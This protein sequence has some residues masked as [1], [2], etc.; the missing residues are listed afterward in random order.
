M[1]ACRLTTVEDP[2]CRLVTRLS[3]SIP[4]ISISGI[5]VVAALASYVYQRRKY[6]RSTIHKL[7]LETFSAYLWRGIG[8]RFAGY[9]QPRLASQLSLRTFALNRLEASQSKVHIPA[10]VPVEL[11]LDDMFVPLTAI[12]SQKERVS[13]EQI[14]FGSYRHTILIGDPGSGKSTIVRKVYRDICRIGIVTQR[15]SQIPVL[16]D[17]KDLDNLRSSPKANGDDR[18]ESIFNLVK[19]EV[20]SVKTYSGEK[21][22]EWFLDAGRLTVMLDGLDEVRTDEF[23]NV[24]KDILALRDQL[25]RRNPRNRLVVTTRRQLYV[26]LSTDFKDA[27]EAHLT[28]EP[29]TAN[30][31]YEF[32]Q[33]WYY[34]TRAK[35]ASAED[36]QAATTEGRAA[37]PEE[38]V[39]RIFN[40]LAEQPNIRTMCATPLVLG[41][42]VAM[43]ELT[44]GQSLPETRPDFYKT[45]TDE[46]LVR[47][48]SRQLGLTTG[49]SLL[50]RNRQRILGR[51]ALEH[52]L[53]E[54]QSRNS[55]RWQS[56]VDLL[57]KEE[58]LPKAEAEIRLRELSRDTG[59][60]T[61][62]QR[63]ET[64]T[65]IHLTFCEFLAAQAISGGATQS[66]TDI[67]RRIGSAAVAKA[68]GQKNVER[69]AE[70]IIFA[71]ALE[72]NETTRRRRIRWI[73]QT[74]ILDIALRAI[75]DSQPYEDEFV[76]KAIGRIADDIANVPKGERDDQWLYLFRQMAI[77]LRDR[78]RVIAGISAHSIA[79]TAPESLASFIRK[80]IGDISAGFEPLFLSYI[81]IDASG[82]LQ[83]ARSMNINTVTQYPA[84]LIGALD[85]P[86]ILA[87][88]LA[89]FSRGDTSSGEWAA[90]LAVAALR[91]ESLSV[92]LRRITYDERISAY[93]LASHSRR[94]VGWHQ[95]WLIR[96][97]MLGLLLEAGCRSPG[98]WDVLKLLSQLPVL[99][100][101]LLERVREITGFGWIV[102]GICLSQILAVGL[103]AV[104]NGLGS[105]H[106]NA[107]KSPLAGTTTVIFIWVFIVAYA[108]FLAV[109]I[110]AV[111]RRASATSYVIGKEMS[112]S[113]FRAADGMVSRTFLERTRYA[114]LDELEER[115][116][117]E[118][119]RT[120]LQIL[121]SFAIIH[122]YRHAYFLRWP[123][124]MLHWSPNSKLHLFAVLRSRRVTD[125]SLRDMTEHDIE[126]RA[127]VT[128]SSA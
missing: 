27:F 61:E 16:I 29:F 58:H 69:F 82:A 107:Q 102:I 84:L 75:V 125:K 87:H 103:P 92:R 9:L 19:Y 79:P 41:M 47:R 68:N 11:N 106:P 89:E 119:N 78:E 34:R 121:K 40:N 60:F 20:T 124:R 17:L 46:L 32:L 108:I 112:T 95:C 127:Q 94:H 49:L 15:D 74:K 110:N 71:A 54:K 6:A 24:S 85:E 98:S 12:P 109:A 96:G 21:L 123:L 7:G 116:L 86:E 44:K 64:L 22:F 18:D 4:T 76:L 114:S 5:S 37:T 39:S 59:L 3:L 128:N 25:M 33:K 72:G 100:S 105:S 67:T 1:S 48:R 120:E 101:R 81:R 14:A 28:L 42:Y 118:I 55:L 117:D 45:V 62:V 2:S 35:H 90:V 122:Q 111:F 63:E 80:V 104:T 83:M 126:P 99:K 36:E 57:S 66:W 77:T 70:V 52:L 26:N 38:H 50:R 43:D 30:D 91:H 115:S 97:T 88:A 53:D 65:F 23:E 51:I 113:R 73:V 93:T 31:M 13:A 10:T 8:Y 56:A